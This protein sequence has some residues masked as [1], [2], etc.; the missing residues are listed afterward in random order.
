MTTYEF[1]R[2][3][4]EYEHAWIMFHALLILGSITLALWV[5]IIN[6]LTKGKFM[7][8]LDGDNGKSYLESFA[9]FI[10]FIIRKIKFK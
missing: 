3:Y 7:Q 4:P 8:F 1:L 6:T 9:D 5:W 10:R 2:L